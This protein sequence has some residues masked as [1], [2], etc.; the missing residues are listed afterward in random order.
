VQS[1]TQDGRK[2]A[3]SKQF[4]FEKK[5]QKTF[6]HKALA[7]PR[8]AH[9]T[10]KSFCFFFSKRSACFLPPLAEVDAYVNLQHERQEYGLPATRR[11][12]HVPAAGCIAH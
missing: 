4:F 7:F 11:G 9:Q 5:N 12:P 2:I 6:V 10:T 8:R 1:K 3:E